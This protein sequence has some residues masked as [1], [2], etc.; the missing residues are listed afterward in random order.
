MWVSSIRRFLFKWGLTMSTGT[1]VLS[2]TCAKETVELKSSSTSLHPL[3]S[4][5]NEFQKTVEL[6]EQRWVPDLSD[7]QKAALQEAFLELVPEAQKD[8]ALLG[9]E[10][11]AACASP[12]AAVVNQFLAKHGFDIKLRQTIGM[13]VA[14]VL[15]IGV[16]WHPGT[17]KRAS[18]NTHYGTFPG[19][20][21]EKSNVVMSPAHP[22]PIAQL[23]TQNNDLVMITKATSQLNNVALVRYLTGLSEVGLKESEGYR[24]VHFPMVRYEET[25]DVS[26]LLGLQIENPNS[27]GLGEMLMRLAGGKFGHSQVPYV[28]NQAIQLT[29]FKLNEVGARVES[30]AAMS[31]ARGGAVHRPATQLLVI[32]EPFY[33]WIK[34]GGM[35][36]PYFVGLF[37]QEHWCDPGSL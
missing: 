33:L 36:Y 6:T 22:Y 14:S 20:L 5:L 32:D 37:A 27:P 7:P 34:R 16:L 31:A 24:G 4:C 10:E 8:L 26:W 23:S 17:A 25:I 18:L 9:A 29:R 15:K 2:S 13:H 3:A 1:E 30:A 12:K 21:A 28:I 35:K 19:V 11:A